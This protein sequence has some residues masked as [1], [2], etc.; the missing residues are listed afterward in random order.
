MVLSVQGNKWQLG[1]TNFS[2]LG[3][4]FKII[5]KQVNKTTKYQ[6]PQFVELLL[7]FVRNSSRIFHGR[8]SILSE[9]REYQILISNQIWKS[10]ISYLLS[11]FKGN[12]MISD[13]SRQIKQLIKTHYIISQNLEASFKIFV[14]QFQE[15]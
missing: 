1:R 10:F 5:L 3:Q 6:E 15:L 11:Q 8:S 12:K 9:E 14:K 13:I 4:I 2:F 7:L